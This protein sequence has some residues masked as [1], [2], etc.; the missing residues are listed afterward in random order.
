M[1]Q[2]GVTEYAIGRMEIQVGFPNREKKCRWCPY[3][4]DDSRM[5]Q[6]RICTETFEII[7]DIDKMGV[8]CPLMF[9]EEPS[10]DNL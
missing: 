4:V 7:P 10:N 8:R 2:G 3:C 9:E 1:K 5:K 6:R